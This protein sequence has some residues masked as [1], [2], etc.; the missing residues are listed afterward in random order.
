M[1]MEWLIVLGYTFALLIVCLFSLEQVYLAFLY[2]RSPKAKK[3]KEN[4]SPLPMVTVQLPVYNE[5]YV[6]ERLIDSVC[7]LDYPKDK[8]EIQ[9]LDDSTDDTRQII[10]RKVQE[11]KARGMDITQVLRPERIG[12]KAGALQYGLEIAKGEFIAIFDADFLPKPDFLQK[13][14]SAFGADTGMVQTR[15]GHI[16]QDFSLLTKLQAFGLNA[17]FTVEQTGRNASGKL[18]NFNGTGGVW[19][20][21]CI[22]AAGGWHHDTLTEDLDL[23]YRAQLKGW[24]FDYL[25]HVLA[26]AELP[27][28]VPA[29]KSQQ[30]RWNKGAA[31]TARKNIGKI[32][33]SKLS[34]VVKLHAVLHLLNSSVFL[35]LFVA[36]VLSI[37]MLFIQNATY[38]MNLLSEISR[39]FF[40]G[41]IAVM[42][43]YWVAAKA[44]NPDFS[45]KYYLTYLPLFVIFSM[46]LS[47]HN[48]I[49]VT[50]GYLG[51]K[52]P[53]I[54]TPKFNIKSKTDSWK[55]NI[56]LQKVF[57][58]LMIIEGGLALYFAGGIIAGIFLQAY[59]LMLFHLMLSVGFGA[60]F[61][62]SF[63]PMGN[64]KAG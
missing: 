62:L 33:R 31:E 60:V 19:R 22:Q 30:Y 59:A 63:N 56:Y 42:I 35:F 44:A 46:G 39:F 26:P 16:N 23:S 55:G 53:F 28:L 12:F 21:T 25:E 52:T 4:L 29:I 34:Y 37:P 6:V 64:V 17:H 2:K 8:L 51:I 5:R 36:A 24:K 38:T 13:T 1:I 48:A 7:E 54:R 11:W 58:P 3:T 10:Q 32:L 47:L 61:F 49:A 43:F 57:S 9:V 15:W 41:F 50:E 45:M 40:V 27:V 14:L 18:M 20:K